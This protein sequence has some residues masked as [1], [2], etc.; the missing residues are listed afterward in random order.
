MC[1]GCF[2]QLLLRDEFH[3]GG[4]ADLLGKAAGMSTRRAFMA[5]SVGAASVLSA[6]GAA[7][8]F[9]ANEGADVILRGGTI[10]PLP[11]ATVS[12]ALAI[13]GGQVLAVGDESALSGLKTGNTKVV[14][15]AGRTLLPGLIDPH[16]HTLLASLIFELLDDVGF[17]KYPTREKVV[18]HLKEAAASM[19]KGQWIVGSNFDNLLQ[20]GDFTRAQLDAISTDQPIFVW[21]TNGHDACVNSEAL[22]I[23]GIS[24]DIDD[25]PGGGHF[26]RG[27]D[28]KLNGLVY[29]ES[30]MLK[31]AVHFLGRI[32]PVVAAKA[33]T[34][35][36]QHM[37]SVG[38][39][40]LH[41]PGTIRSDWIEQFATL[42]NTLAC[43]TSASVMFDDMK[44]LTPW[45]SLGLGP[46]GAT[47]AESM[48][49]L[50]GVKI[51]GDGSNQTETGAQTKPY[52][53]ST[54]KGSPNFDAAQMKQMVAEVKAFGLPTLIHSNGDYTIDIALDAIEA[55][56]AGSTDYGINRIEHATMARPDQILR[57]KKLNVQPSFLMN[58][59]RF[60]GAAYRDQIFGP[61]RAAFMDP[62]AACVKAGLPFTL[63][64]D[65]PCSPPGPLALIGTAVTRRCIIDNS[66]VGP[67]QAVSL[68]DAI[69]AVTINA[70]R[71][72]GQGD[73]LGSLEKGKE[74]DF[75]ILES[76]PYKVSPDAIADIKVSETW[77]AGERKFAA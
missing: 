23:A 67:D 62:V 50:Y 52:L 31:F 63:H 20:G 56:Y 65:A 19:P 77:V 35:Y 53:N 11:G 33:V 18:A 51:I 28:G 59:L 69:R 39:T 66:V 74:A 47:V 17:A 6:V 9:A 42:S 41:E 61:E 72:I 4:M 30:A 49:S 46:K 57:M 10:R 55:A 7:P 22:K 54:A 40:M 27:A 14:D 3:S 64:T 37:G 24:E 13:K 43:R 8:A 15:L 70:A 21:Y 36:A 76:D 32:T 34:H 16:C 73:R 68:D 45:R 44:G 1:Q 58:H 2:N 48:F 29:E 25:L 38:N 71:Q 5:Y 12:S 26:G 75:T 60:Y